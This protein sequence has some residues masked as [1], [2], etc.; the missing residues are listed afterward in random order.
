MVHS[1]EEY[2]AS[3]NNKEELKKFVIDYKNSIKPVLI[4]SSN[5]KMI[6]WLLN[7]LNSIYNDCEIKETLTYV[8]VKNKRDYFCKVRYR[9]CGMSN[10]ISSQCKYCNEKLNCGYM[11]DKRFIKE[12]KYK[13][14]IINTRQLVNKLMLNPKFYEG[15]S[16]VALYKNYTDSLHIKLSKSELEQLVIKSRPKKLNTNEK[17]K[18]NSICDKCSKLINIFFN[19]LDNRYKTIKNRNSLVKELEKLE[20][21]EN[22]HVRYFINK[23]KYFDINAVTE[24]KENSVV[25]YKIKIF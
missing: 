20:Y 15:Y 21:Y 19:N 25:S 13:Y 1:R 5:Q 10:V 23:L 16:K 18:I 2:I 14:E 9:D 7:D 17:E 12:Q 6:K 3:L 22:Y 11:V 4:C 8:V 24:I